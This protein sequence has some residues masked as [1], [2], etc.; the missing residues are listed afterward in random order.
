M[1]SPRGVLHRPRPPGGE[2]SLLPRERGWGAATCGKVEEEEGG[3]EEAREGRRWEDTVGNKIKT[4]EERKMIHP[5]LYLSVHPY[6][7]MAIAV[8]CRGGGKAV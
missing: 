6:V 2:K 7:Q 5:A 8:A 3:R 4:E 1:E